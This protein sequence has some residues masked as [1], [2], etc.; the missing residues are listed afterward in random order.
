MRKKVFIKDFQKITHNGFGS[1]WPSVNGL[2]DG[3]DL[4]AGRQAFV[5][6]NFYLLIVL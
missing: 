4:P 1:A 6:C 3:Y 2:A 5:I